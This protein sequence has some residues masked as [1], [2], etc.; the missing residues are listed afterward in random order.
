MVYAPVSIT[1]ESVRP[2]GFGVAPLYVA[3]AAEG[4]AKLANAVAGQN[5]LIE[6]GFALA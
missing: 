6:I 5:V 3:P 2:V 1:D 4:K